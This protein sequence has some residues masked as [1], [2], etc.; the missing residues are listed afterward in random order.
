M[1]M[2]YDIV[3]RRYSRLDFIPAQSRPSS[4]IRNL[5]ST[6]ASLEAFI[7]EKLAI[8]VFVHMCHYGNQNGFEML[9]YDHHVW[10][11]L[12][13][14]VVGSITSD[15]QLQLPLHSSKHFYHTRESCVRVRA[16]LT[17]NVSEEDKYNV[18]YLRTNIDNQMQR[19][20]YDTGIDWFR[21]HGIP[22]IYVEVVVGSEELP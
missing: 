22:K 5:C 12:S 11:H 10:L 3:H 8:W 16:E 1:K 20:K 17:R 13:L 7:G 21:A 2:L 14:L 18:L 4:Q 9:Q 15:E 19:A 6:L